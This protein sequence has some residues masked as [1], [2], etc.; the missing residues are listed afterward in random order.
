MNELKNIASI[1]DR[2]VDVDELQSFK[3]HSRPTNY[4]PYTN[5]DMNE[6]YEKIASRERS[7]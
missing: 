4:V 3:I 6:V 7:K 2:K 1:L 5:D